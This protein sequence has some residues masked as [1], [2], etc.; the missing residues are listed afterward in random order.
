MCNY[1]VEQIKEIKARADQ[2]AREEASKHEDRWAC[3]FAWLYFSGVKGN[4]RLG[5]TLKSA[6]IDFGHIN[7]GSRREFYI[8]GTSYFPGQSIDAHEACCRAAAKVWHEAG[9]D[10]VRVGSRL[11]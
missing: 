5:R 2:A 7:S 9:F 4:T 3:G 1:T 6:G 8:W 11:D 10:C